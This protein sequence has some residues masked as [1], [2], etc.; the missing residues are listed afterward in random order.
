M[1]A[2]FFQSAHRLALTSI[3][4]LGVTVGCYFLEIIYNLIFLTL[5][6]NLGESEDMSG[7]EIMMVLAGIGL[8]I[9]KL[10]AYVGSIIFFLM[11]LHRAYK[12]LEAMNVRNLDASAGWAVGYWFI[13]IL[14]LFKPMKVVAEVYNGS[15]PEIAKAGYGFSDAGANSLIGFWWA[16][17]VLSNITSRI[18]DAIEKGAKDVTDT[19]VMVYI[20]ALSFGI[21]AGILLIFIIREIDERQAEGEL[22]MS[23]RQIAPPPPPPP[24]FNQTNFNQTTNQSF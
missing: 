4:F 14:N 16:F 12:N 6:P 13:P 2:N 1:S 7:G 15:D 9:M 23:R 18:A 5:F 11:W 21:I 19:S 10:T 22:F 8:I 17:W 24:T 20:V 3:I